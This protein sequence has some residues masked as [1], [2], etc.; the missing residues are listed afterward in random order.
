[1]ELLYRTR[2]ALTGTSIRSDGEVYA[3]QRLDNGETVAIKFIHKHWV[4]RPR[5][6]KRFK[7]EVVAARKVAHPAVVKVLDLGEVDYRPYIVMEFLKGK[8][9]ADC[10]ASNALRVIDAIDLVIKAVEL[11][12]AHSVGLVHRDFKPENM[13]VLGH[14]TADKRIKLLDFGI[15]RQLDSVGHTRTGTTMGTPLFMSRSRP[16]HRKQ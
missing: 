10:M 8:S 14:D 3:A 13:I 16:L 12:A 15:A 6:V 11:A 2:I 4:S 7:E 5:G 9:L 1:M